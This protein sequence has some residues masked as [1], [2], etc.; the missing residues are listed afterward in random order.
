MGHIYIYIYTIATCSIFTTFRSPQAD[1]KQWIRPQ[2]LPHPVDFET[3]GQA[4]LPMAW[5]MNPASE[6]IFG[7]HGSSS[8]SECSPETSNR[9]PS[10]TK[11]VGEKYFFPVKPETL[12]NP[13][14]V[15]LSPICVL[16][17]TTSVHVSVRSV[18]V[19]RGYVPSNF[20]T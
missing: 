9:R 5:P 2:V 13:K 12:I 15:F 17:A 7:L 8:G 10:T 16:S 18:E 20:Q 6:C 14:H 3:S 11:H 4:I 1:H 19:S